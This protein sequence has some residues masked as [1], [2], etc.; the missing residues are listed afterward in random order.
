MLEWLRSPIVY[1]EAFSVGRLIAAALEQTRSSVTYDGS[2]RRIAD[3]VAA[4][5]ERFLRDERD[6]FSELEAS[7]RFEL[8]HA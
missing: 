7:G 5:I 1:R 2:Y 8:L 6:A 4:A 3:E